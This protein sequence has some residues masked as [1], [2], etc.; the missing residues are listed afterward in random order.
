MP[1]TMIV[2][3]AGQGPKPAR[4]VQPKG[5]GRKRLELACRRMESIFLE[6][7]L[8]QMR[9]TVPREGIIGTS[10]A[11]QLYQS[12][13]DQELSRELSR[14]K[15][16]GLAEMIKQQLLRDQPGEMKK[17]NLNAKVSKRAADKKIGRPACVD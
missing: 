1:E 4:P 9:K 15:S 2:G 14:R 11:M 6:Y 16:L 17:T 7:M 8:G 5:D 12:L 13:Y 3:K 10:N